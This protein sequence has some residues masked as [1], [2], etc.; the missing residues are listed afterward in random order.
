MTK[1]ADIKYRDILFHYSIG[2]INK[3]VYEKEK[4][5][6]KEKCDIG[7]IFGGVSMIPFRVEN[8]IELYNKKLVDRLLVSG[9]IGFQNLDRKNTEASK[10]R[11][12]L[13]EKGIPEQDILVEESSRSTLENIRNTLQM[14]K[15]DYTSE[16]IPNVKFALVTSDFHVR[17]CLSMF[18]LQMDNFNQEE[19]DGLYSLE[20]IKNSLSAFATKDKIH[21]KGI[22]QASL[23]G[24]KM[25]LQEAISLCMYAK[26]EKIENLEISDL[27]L[28]RSRK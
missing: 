16:E 10:M 11:R 27:S 2:E 7:F 23:A 26:K 20:K 14:L 25:I 28:K 6:V 1:L 3:I 8:G 18:A 13:L 12:Y 9:G 22:W 15:K 17:R 5:E 4:V 21:D 24:R 19:L